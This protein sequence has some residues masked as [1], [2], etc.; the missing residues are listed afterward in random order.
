MFSADLSWVD[1]DTEKVGERRER[2][3]K[4]R[5]STSAAPSLRN[6]ISSKSSIFDNRELWWTSGLKKA[7]GLKPSKKGRPDTSHSTPDTR[8]ASNSLPRTLQHEPSDDLR[9]PTLQPAWTYSTT[10]STTL[11]SGAPLD[12]PEHEVPELEGD[13]SSRCTN[14]SGSRSSR[15]SS[16]TSSRRSSIKADVVR[17]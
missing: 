16:N 13:L 6:S 12:P 8:K 3:A 15:K 4:E 5:S 17:R 11:P 10:L 2:I 7:K 9:D 14:S 1:P